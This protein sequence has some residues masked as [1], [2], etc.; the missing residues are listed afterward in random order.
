MT[1]IQ[2]KGT[3]KMNRQV[4]PNHCY[5]AED[6]SMYML[7]PANI[8][9]SPEWHVEKDGRRWRTFTSLTAAK[10]WLE[11]VLEHP[12]S[13]RPQPRVTVAGGGL[14]L[15]SALAAMLNGGKK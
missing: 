14:T 6:G 2:T 15:K 13:D 3:Y 10:G 8:H 1:F 4:N 7:V 9:G 11:H 5:E 12:E